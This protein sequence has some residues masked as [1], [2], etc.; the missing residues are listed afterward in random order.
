MPTPTHTAYYL[1]L[2]GKSARWLDLGTASGDLQG[3]F[4]IQLDR[5]P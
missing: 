2:D 1:D 5:L 3:R 4:D